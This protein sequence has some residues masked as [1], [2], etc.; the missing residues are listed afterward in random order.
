M[1]ADPAKILEIETGSMGH[2]VLESFTSA[3]DFEVSRASEMHAFGSWFD[4]AFALPGAAN[5]D[6]TVLSTGPSKPLTH[7]KQDLL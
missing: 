5:A 7:W 3:V 6:V 2:D 1:L 4:V